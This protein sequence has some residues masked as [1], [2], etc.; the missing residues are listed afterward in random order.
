[1]TPSPRAWS[2]AGLMHRA[3]A[4]DVLACVHWGGRLRLIATLHDPVVIRKILAH[5]DLAHSG[6][7]PGPTRTRRRRALIAPG[8]GARAPFPPPLTIRLDPPGPSGRCLD[9]RRRRCARLDAAQPARC[10]RLPRKPFMCAVPAAPA[11]LPRPI[12]RDY[13]TLRGSTDGAASAGGR[14][15]RLRSGA[16]RCAYGSCVVGGVRA[17]EPTSRSRAPRGARGWRGSPRRAFM[18]PI[19]PQSFSG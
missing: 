10:S 9:A 12:M 13:V 3:F 4:I 15:C 14:S 2:W 6:Q 18:S 7:S 19:L 8:R 17:C 5:L 1:M 11:S 16:G